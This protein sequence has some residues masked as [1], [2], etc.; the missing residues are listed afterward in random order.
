MAEVPV[1]IVGKGEDTEVKF[2]EGQ[3]NTVTVTALAAKTLLDKMDNNDL[4]AFV[5]VSEE[6]TG[7]HELPIQLNGPTDIRL[8]SSEDSA[9]VIITNK[10]E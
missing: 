7:E 4:Q 10:T 8:E 1:D 3:A 9:R 2:A 5:D 6:G